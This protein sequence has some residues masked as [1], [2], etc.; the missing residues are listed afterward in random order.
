MFSCR[1]GIGRRAGK[2]D[3]FYSRWAQAVP[4][5]GPGMTAVFTP[6]GAEFH[7]VHAIFLGAKGDLG[8][9]DPMGS[10][11]FLVGR[12]PSSGAP[13]CRHTVKFSIAVCIQESIC[14]TPAKRAA[15]NPSTRWRRARDPRT[16]AYNTRP[17]FRL[18]RA[19]GCTPPDLTE[20][21]SGNLSGRKPR[22]DQRRRPL[23]PARRPHRR[24]RNGLLRRFAAVGDRSGDLLRDLH[25]RHRLGSRDW[26][27][28]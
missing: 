21:G 14:C 23:S 27:S 16:F 1:A 24:F 12:D 15:S 5:P 22:P 13:A 2:S 26:R 20:D 3:V 9:L 6:E 18:M 10:A 25:G 28:A 11:N 17:R 19:A 8:G 7:D 4:D